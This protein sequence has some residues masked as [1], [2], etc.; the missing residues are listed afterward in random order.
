M[1]RISLI[2]LAGLLVGCVSEEQQQAGFR[3]QCMS[4]GAMPGTPEFVQCMTT[5][6][7]AEVQRRAIINAGILGNPYY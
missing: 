2:L 1:R 4:F 7:A 5:L 3:A 6:T